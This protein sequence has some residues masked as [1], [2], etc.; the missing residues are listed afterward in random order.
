MVCNLSKAQISVDSYGNVKLAG[1]LNVDKTTPNTSWLYPDET[2][3]A[4][5][6]ISGR[7]FLN[8]YSKN[9]Y[10]TNINATTI[11]A[12]TYKANGV[13]FESDE[14][15]KENFRNIESPLEK[16]IQL[17]GLKYDYI[18]EASDSTLSIEEIEKA[19]KLKKNRLGFIAQDVEKIL[20]EAVFYDKDTDMYYI[21][22][23]ALIPVI[24]EAMKEQQAKIELLEDEIEAMNDKSKDKSASISTYA[25][26]G[27]A[28]SNAPSLGQNVPNPFNISTRI[29][30]YLPNSVASAKLYIYNMQGSQVKSFTINERGNTSITIEGSSLE[31]GM[32]LYTLIAD[33]REV[34][35]KKMILTK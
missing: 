9:I 18:I 4:S 15:I 13:I 35:T 11:D 23:T 6:G 27:I 7:K 19:T 30:I 3:K 34:D 12:I 10:A 26:E 16:I 2:E 8:C 1:D 20:P 32:Y 22:Y 25:P 17:S 28:V 24:V 14:R 33:G 31:A 29:D 5:L 21:E